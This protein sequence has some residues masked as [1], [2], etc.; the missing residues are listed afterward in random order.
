M[1][2]NTKRI[3]EGMVEKQMCRKQ[4]CE[5]AQITELGFAQLMKRGSCMPTTAGKIAKA[6]EIPASEIVAE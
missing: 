3:W 2:I 1:K 4:V 5:A 6:L